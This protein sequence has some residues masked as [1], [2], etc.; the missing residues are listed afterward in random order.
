[1]NKPQLKLS[2][3][4]E[5]IKFKHKGQIIKCTLEP[6][7]NH[8]IVVAELAAPSTSFGY[9]V[10]LCHD[11]LEK[12]STSQDELRQK[13]ILFGYPKNEADAIVSQVIELTNVFTKAAFPKLK[14][15]VLK[16]KEEERLIQI[17]ADA[18]TVKYTDLIYNIGW[19]LEFEPAHAAT[20]LKT[21]KK[22]LRAMCRGNQE[23]Q[24]KALQIINDAQIAK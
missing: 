24:A 5:W 3:L 16:A 19:V 10:G 15:V 2:Q 22:L 14:K 17:S 20:Y 18:Q 7:Y 9:E 13:L 21:K 23:L 6:Y 11:L 12:T 4:S 8:L 1:M